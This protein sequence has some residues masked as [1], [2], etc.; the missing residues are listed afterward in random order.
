MRTEHLGKRPLIDPTA[1]IAPTAIVSGDVHVGAGSV[2]LAGAIV[3][4]QGAPVRI[5]RSCI[6]MEHAVL[7]G[8][9]RYPC[10]L[11]NYVLV[12]PHAH[13]AGATVNGRAFVATGASIFNGAVLEVRI[14][15]DRDSLWFRA[16]SVDHP[17]RALSLVRRGLGL[18]VDRLET[19]H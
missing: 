15:D 13:I 8:A 18:D 17:H 14:R 4:S 3:T 9:G 2:I 10:T 5:G 16:R 19:F 7:R 6:V 12:G 1:L 11:G